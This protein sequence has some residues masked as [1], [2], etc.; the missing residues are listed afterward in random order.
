MSEHL[1]ARI[2]AVGRVKAVVAALFFAVVLL[3]LRHPATIIVSTLDLLLI[4]VLVW[5]GRR[6]PRAAT[7]L[8]VIETSLFLTPRQFAQG[9]VNGINWPIYI[10]IPLIAAYVLRERRA[11]WIAAGI[12]ALIAVPVMLLAALTLP[13]AIKLGDVLT[14]AAFVLGLLVASAGVVADLFDRSAQQR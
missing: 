2:A 9:Y 13:P 3:T 5:L 8:L 7:Y 14:L 12:T 11:T 4:P 1:S 10:V 6:H